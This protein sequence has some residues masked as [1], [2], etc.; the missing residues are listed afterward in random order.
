MAMM[1]VVAKCAPDVRRSHG[2]I[3]HKTHNQIAVMWKSFSLIVLP[4]SPTV[5]IYTLLTRNVRGWAD[6]LYCFTMF[7]TNVFW[8]IS[9]IEFLKS[10]STVF[11]KKLFLS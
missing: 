8:F 3:S 9:G 5:K 11:G 6:I 10:R 4:I 7:S 2:W 1:R